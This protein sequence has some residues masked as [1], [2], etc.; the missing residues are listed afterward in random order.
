MAERK[1]PVIKRD[2]LIRSLLIGGLVLALAMVLLLSD[3]ALIIGSR[4]WVMPG[5]PMQPG[6]GP[7]DFASVIDDYGAHIPKVRHRPLFAVAARVPDAEPRE[8]NQA[9][10]E[11]ARPRPLRFGYSIRELDILGMPFVP[12]KEYGHVIY[13]ETPYEFVGAQATDDYLKQVKIPTAKPLNDWDFPY[14]Q[15]MWGW[16]WLIGLIGIGLF[17]LGALRRRREALGLI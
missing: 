12:H 13:Y 7:P 16:L 8:P 5:N 14:W 4:S 6:V 1:H 17:E 10:P 3:R 15:H 9:N 2:E 11:S